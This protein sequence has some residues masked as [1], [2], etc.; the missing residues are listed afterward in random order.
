M[1]VQS[2][3]SYNETLSILR[4]AIA[5]AGNTIFADIDQSG[6]AAAVGLTLR[7]TTLLVF[8]NPRGGT[9]LMDAYPEFALELPLKILVWEGSDGVELAYTPLK[10]SAAWHGVAE[11][12]DRIAHIDAAVDALVRLVT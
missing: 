11:M 1:I 8:G 9:P 6:A 4:Q 2:R 3:H 12:D 7:P 5:D 10:E